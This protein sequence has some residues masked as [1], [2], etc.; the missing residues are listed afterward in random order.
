MVTA[1]NGTETALCGVH[2]Y[3]GH[4]SERW[5]RVDG[6]LSAIR[7]SCEESNEDLLK[8]E[9]VRQ[10]VAVS[11]MAELECAMSE[12]GCGFTRDSP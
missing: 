9:Q 2:R 11:P 8:L 10:S 12:E 7:H 3:L 1:T 5:A 4:K 6:V